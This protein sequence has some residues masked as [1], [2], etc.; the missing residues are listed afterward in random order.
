MS[1]SPTDRVTVKEHVIFRALGDEAI[2]LNL[3]GGLYFGLDEVG[4]RIWTL[5]E[6]E[7][8][9]GVAAALVDE[10]DVS[11]ETADVDVAAFVEALTGKGLVHRVGD[12]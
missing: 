12:R 1:W 11:R 9:A 8:L 3:D 4:T 7:D 10:Y 5:L 2:V 6:T